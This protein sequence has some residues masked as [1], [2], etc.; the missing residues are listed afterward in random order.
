MRRHSGFIYDAEV[1]AQAAERAFRCGGAGLVSAVGSRKE[2]E[3]TGLTS[4]ED[5]IVHRLSQECA[6]V[7]MAGHSLGIRAESK[8]VVAPKRRDQWS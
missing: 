2:V 8:L 1:L 3:R 5:A 6:I 4:E 7:S